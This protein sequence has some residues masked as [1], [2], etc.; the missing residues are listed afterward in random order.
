MI[1]MFMNR[2]FGEQR[3]SK[4]ECHYLLGPATSNAFLVTRFVAILQILRPDVFCDIGAY[5]GQTS[6]MMREAL[7]SAAIHAFEA[8]PE[9]QRA[10]STNPLLAGLSY[11]NVAVCDHDGT[12]RILAPRSVTVLY[13]D[14]DATAGTRVVEPPLTKKS[15][16]RF[17]NGKTT[18]TEHC[19]PACRLDSV[20]AERL[21]TGDRFALWIDVEGAADKI[22]SGACETLK[23]TVAVFIEVE[24]YSF[25]RRQ[26]KSSEIAR[27]LAKLGFVPVAR[28]NEYGEY[29]YNIVFVKRNCL[30]AL[31][32]W[33]QSQA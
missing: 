23:N 9:V 7:P 17:R 6:I 12:T 25:W 19:V 5:D 22:L 18:Y 27:R 8:N 29:Q 21:T 13:P 20:F 14:G 11:E 15:S 3:P 32:G 16:L 30:P 26:V 4:D 33:L 10:Y 1:G 2:L 31:E 24:N 28:D